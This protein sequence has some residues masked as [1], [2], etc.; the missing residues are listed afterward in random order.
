MSLNCSICKHFE[1]GINLIKNY[2]EAGLKMGV[3]TSFYMLLLN[4]QSEPHKIAYD[5]HLKGKGLSIHQQ[6]EA[7]IK[8]LEM[9]FV[10]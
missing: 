4:M 6:S 2:N 8:I 10:V 7:Q 3:N 9:S 1:D 5:L